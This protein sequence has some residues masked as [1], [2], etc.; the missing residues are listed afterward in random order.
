[1]DRAAGPLELAVDPDQSEP[2]GRVPRRSDA[3][4]SPRLYQ[5][6]E[7]EV[8]VTD[9]E[10]TLDANGK[11]TVSIPTEVSEHRWDA[12]YRWKPASPMQATAKSPA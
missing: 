2:E 11:L 1:M 5:K 10:G 3:W 4:R 6:P 9:R 8:R 7:Y 12:R